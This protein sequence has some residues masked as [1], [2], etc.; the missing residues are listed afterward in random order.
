MTTSPVFSSVSKR[1]VCIVAFA[2]AG[3]LLP[4]TVRAKETVLLD[5]EQGPLSTRWTAVGVV[6]ATRKAI[7]PP[8]AAVAD[9]PTGQGVTVKTE[10]GGGIYAKSGT[11]PADWRPYASISFW[12]YRSPDE[13][14]RHAKSAIE[15]QMYEADGK[16]KFWR[17]FE[18]NHTGWQRYTADLKWFRWGNGRV[19]RWDRVDRAGFW[20]R[21]AAELTIDR[22]ALTRGSRANA[23]V[24]SPEDLAAVAFPGMDVDDATIVRRKGFAL[25]SNSADLDAAKL[26]DHLEKVRRRVQ[27]EWSAI[28]KPV[29]DAVLI[30]FAEEREYQKFP[31]R[32]AAEMN[33]NAAETTSGGYSIQGVSTSFWLAE[34]GTLRPVY[35]HEFVHSLITHYGRIGDAG[36]WF[37]DGMAN[38]YQLQFHP[39]EGFDRIVRAGL[40]N[41]DYRTP[42]SE[43][44]TGKSIESHRY[45]QA[46]TLVEMMLADDKFRQQLPKLIAAFE[47]ASSTDLTP[48]LKPVFD[49]DWDGRGENDAQGR[50]LS[51]VL[52]DEG[53]GV[54][55]QV[56]TAGQSA[57]VVGE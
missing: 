11:L 42:F 4:R 40:E 19:A 9:G 23:A 33:S 57:D 50:G 6:N 35:T 36:G 8:D 32:F 49:T 48:H 20:F 38:Y 44:C 29:E 54:V 56:E 18:V 53:N 47:K 37:Q 16:A 52:D 24:P 30:V 2:L 45:W 7:A 25:I 3:L 51:S 13:S 12:V 1:L 41:E 27:S 31:P 55:P 17:K 21:D 39:Q 22:I 10:G 5:F 34:R 14:K 46:L 26:A 43:L 15:L 28:S